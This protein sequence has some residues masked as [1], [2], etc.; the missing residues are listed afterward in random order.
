M[1]EAFELWKQWLEKNVRRGDEKKEENNQEPPFMEDKD[2][3]K[4]AVVWPP[5]ISFSS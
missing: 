4:K 1:R 2:M 3:K 5:N